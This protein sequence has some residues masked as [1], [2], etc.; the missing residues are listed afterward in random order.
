MQL[1][2]SETLLRHINQILLEWLD[3]KLEVQNI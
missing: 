1:L 3:H 2:F